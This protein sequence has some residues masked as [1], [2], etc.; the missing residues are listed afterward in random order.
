[1]Q[2]ANY[3]IAGLDE[4]YTWAAVTNEDRTSGFL[5]SRTPTID[6]ADLAAAVQSFVEV[7]VDPCALRPTRQDGGAQHPTELC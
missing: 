1:S 2:E 7:G 6:D 5:L 4:S 3:V